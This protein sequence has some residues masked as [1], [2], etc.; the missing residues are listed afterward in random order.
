M[1]LGL[2]EVWDLECTIAKLTELEVAKQVLYLLALVAFLIDTLK[3]FEEAEQEIVITE[4]VRVRPWYFPKILRYFFQLLN[5]FRSPVFLSRRKTRPI[6]RNNNRKI[7]LSPNIPRF[8]YKVPQLFTAP[9]V[10]HFLPMPSISAYDEHGLTFPIFSFL[11]RSKTLI[12]P[13]ES[14]QNAIPSSLTWISTMG[15]CYFG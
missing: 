11:Q 13:T 7:Y 4:H 9:P 3:A 15:I 2:A 1:A 12:L 8:V 10:T 6:D 5:L 14:R